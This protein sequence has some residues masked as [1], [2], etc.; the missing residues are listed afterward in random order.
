MSKL[1][2]EIQNLTKNCTEYL[3]L[4]MLNE[5]YLDLGFSEKEAVQKIQIR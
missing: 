5:F 1:I 4:G 3:I 2:F